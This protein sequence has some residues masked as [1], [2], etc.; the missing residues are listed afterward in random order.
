MKK[1][2]VTIFFTL[3]IIENVL[4]ADLVYGVK[5]NAS[6]SKNEIYSINLATGESTLK[7]QFAFTGGNWQPYNSFMDSYNG[8]YYLK[9]SDNFFYCL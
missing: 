4:G 2:I 8:K 3:V 9:D 7:Q 1:I 5:Y 6:I